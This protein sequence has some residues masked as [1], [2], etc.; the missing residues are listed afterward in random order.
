MAFMFR[1]ILILQCLLIPAILTDNNNEQK[2]NYLKYFLDYMNNLP[3]QLY[4]Y[5]DG[6]LVNVQEIVSISPHFVLVLSL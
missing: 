5:E 4:A 2:K 1:Y 6:I 3:D